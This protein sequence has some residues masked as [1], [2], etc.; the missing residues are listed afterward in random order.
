MK[1]I[2]RFLLNL[3]WLVTGGALMALGY[4]IAGVICCI[5]IITI[6]FGVAS[7]RMARY[8]LWPFGARLVGIPESGTAAR[9]GNVI[10]ILV[11]GWW[12]ALGH[13]LTTITQTVSIVGIPAA[14]AN[15]KMIPVSLTPLGHEVVATDELL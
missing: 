15:I 11:A 14:I 3:I 5:L 4:A 6:P 8:A 2:A 12:L 1:S 13:L 7:F 10:W 9:I